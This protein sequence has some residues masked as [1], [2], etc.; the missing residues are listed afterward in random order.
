VRLIREKPVELLKVG[1]WCI[2][3]GAEFYSAFSPINP[4]IA[5]SGSWARRGVL[6]PC[7]PDEYVNE[8]TGARIDEHSQG[9]AFDNVKPP[10]LQSESV[11]REIACRERKCE[12]TLEP[13][14][15][16][17]F[18]VGTDVS[19]VAWLQRVHMRIDNL[20]GKFDLIVVGSWHG[21]HFPSG[22][23]EKKEGGRR[24]QPVPKKGPGHSS[25]GRCGAKIGVYLFPE[26]GRRGL[27]ELRELQSL[28]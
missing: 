11:V 16:S 27:I 26:R 14:V 21:I 19:Q 5:L 15:H 18:I 10:T 9:A 22:D 8:M 20:L 13:T 4:L 2:G 7:G 17:L 24:G 12:S 23:C 25:R 6:F 1:G 3:D 28:T